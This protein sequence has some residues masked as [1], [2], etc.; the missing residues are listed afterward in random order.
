M[1]ALQHYAPRVPHK[2]ETGRKIDRFE[3]ITPPFYPG[4]APFERV[5]NSDQKRSLRFTA[6]TVRRPVRYL[7]FRASFPDAKKKTRTRPQLRRAV[8]INPRVRGG[9]VCICRFAYRTIKGRKGCGWKEGKTVKNKNGFRENYAGR[10][11]GR[12]RKMN[13]VQNARPGRRRRR[14]WRAR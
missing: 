2:G 9:P 11:A 10:P 1:L 8:Y 3:S 13:T 5:P 7:F 6:Y 14:R 4:S 12:V